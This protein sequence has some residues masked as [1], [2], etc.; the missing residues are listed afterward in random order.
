MR[1]LRRNGRL[2]RACHRLPIAFSLLLVAVLLLAYGYQPPEARDQ[3]SRYLA[4]VQTHYLDTTAFR[5]HYLRAG[6]GEPVVL[7]PG[8]GTWLYELRSLIAALAPHYTVYAL[9]PP[10]SGYTTPR[11]ERPRY[12]LPAIDQTLL[13]FMDRLGIAR[14]TL[15]GHSFGGGYALYF[16][17]QHPERVSGLVLLASVGLDLPYAPLF[18]AMQ[19]PVLGELSTKVVTPELM[20]GQLEQLVADPATITEELVR[21]TYIPATFHTNRVALY[22]LTR[23]LDWR[24]T[25]TGLAQLRVPVLLIWGREDQL[26]PVARLERWQE[27]LPHAE[28]R[29]IEGAGH[30]LQEDQ[31]ELVNRAVLAFLRR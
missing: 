8:G 3:E 29:V 31:P 30:L 10:G 12:D 7:L 20:R 14:S 15:V 27:L 11:V 28:V 13:E 5:V 9:D 17:E 16:A 19:W 21:E 22:Q 26:Q 23:Q 18:E 4:Q 2:A 25:E 24:L 1:I 6:Y